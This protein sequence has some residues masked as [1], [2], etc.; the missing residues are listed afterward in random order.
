MG[1]RRFGSY[2]AVLLAAGLVVSGCGGGDKGGDNAGG[3]NVKTSCSIAYLTATAVPGK[4]V[5]YKST[6]DESKLPVEDT[7][8]KL[9]GSLIKDAK[10]R[11]I[12]EKGKANAEA[13][14]AALA[15][16]DNAARD[17]AIVD[18]KPIL[19]E[20]KAACSAANPD[21][22][23][24]IGYLEE[25]L[26]SGTLPEPVAKA[27]PAPTSAA[28]PTSSAAPS[29]PKP[30]PLP[31]VTPRGTKVKL[32]QPVIVELVKDGKKSLA[33]MTVTA[34]V[35]ATDDDLKVLKKDSLKGILGV[36]FVRA[37]FKDIRPEGTPF[38]PAVP[39]VDSVYPEFEIGTA[40]GTTWT[41]MITFGEFKPCKDSASY[42]NDGVRKLCTPFAITSGSTDV[43]AAALTGLEIGKT[44]SNNPLY[45][46]TR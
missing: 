24:A 8:L 12:A 3:A 34:I 17:K 14:N 26:A 45:T 38:D 32:G 25:S 20:Y 18:A 37:D 27:G 30:K 6:G 10:V 31:V 40:D 4:L 36:F 28:A 19:D 43:R 22:N 29:K 11:A 46:W 35:K 39:S 42:N 9:A 41:K 1:M 23:G 2:G 7:T 44:D 13:F 33:Q 15:K 21:L 5:A 16:K